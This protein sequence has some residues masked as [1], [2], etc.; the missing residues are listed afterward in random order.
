[1]KDITGNYKTQVYLR[2][3][4]ICYVMMFKQVIKF[5]NNVTLKFI[6]QQNR[7]NNYVV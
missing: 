2:G 1:M 4:I 5:K 7:Y 3:L 6:F